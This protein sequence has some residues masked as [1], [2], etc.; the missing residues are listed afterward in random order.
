MCECVSVLQCMFVDLSLSHPLSFS[1][2]GILQK[3]QI[4]SNAFW[5]TNLVT[6]LLPNTATHTHTQNHCKLFTF[7]WPP[8]PPPHQDVEHKWNMFKGLIEQNTKVK[9]FFGKTQ[10]GSTFKFDSKLNV[11]KPNRLINVQDIENLLFGKKTLNFTLN[12]KPKHHPLRGLS[13]R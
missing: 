4:D 11:P 8:C 7:N 5:S 2:L 1:F 10:P 6:N 12:P 3:P 13:S 9:R